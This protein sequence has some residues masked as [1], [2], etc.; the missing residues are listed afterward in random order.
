M[1]KIH[2]PYIYF[3]L[4]AA[5]ILFSRK[6]NAQSFEELAAK[7]P[8]DYAVIQN[9]SKSLTI[10]MKDGQPYAESKNEQDILVLDDKANGA[11]N[12]QYIYNN[13]YN[14][15]LDFEAYTKVPDGKKYNKIKVTDVKTESARSRS[16]FYDDTK[17]TGF[18]FPSLVKGAIAHMEYSEA[19][20]DVHMLIPFYCES[21]I[22]VV[23]AVYTVTLPTDM[24]L[25]YTV[26]NDAAKK[27][28][29]TES[30][31]GR[32]HT[33]TFT[34]SDIK[35]TDRFSN[36]PAAS[37]YEPH[38][39]IQ[40]VSYKN[41][42]GETV[43]FLGNV[44]DLYKWDYGFISR[45]NN[46]SKELKLLADSLTAGVTND[47]VKARKIYEW[48]QSNI[49]YVAFEDGLEG[50][51]PRPA[52]AICTRRYGD[53]KDMASILTALLQAAGLKAYFTWIGTRDIPYDYNDVPLPITD[54]HMIAALNTGNDW[55]FLDGTDPNCI[56][57][58]PSAFI[59]GKQAMIAISADEYKIIRVPEVDVNKSTLVDSTYITLSDNGIKGF[60]SVY[61]DG[62]FGSDIYTKLMYSDPKETKDYVKYRMGKASNKFILGNFNISKLDNIAKSVN[63]QADFE[64]P[65]YS[66]KISD[67]LYINL[68]LEK[69]FTDYS[70]IDTARRK[71]PMEN[72]YKYSIKQY[73][74]LEIP[75][76][77]NVTYIPKDFTVDNPS[78]SFAIKYTKQGNKIIA[79]QEF[80]NNYLLMQ[81]KDFPDWNNA[82]KKINN[83][84]KEQVVLEARK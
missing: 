84:Y 77:Y 23:N 33:Y 46:E 68:N 35:P 26:L 62:Y 49:K 42:K 67:E 19:Y 70:I 56:F 55:I 21:Y 51:V 81:P 58:L 8:N 69:L 7:Y 24:Q 3:F 39:I 27:I 72:D 28:N 73:T 25:K 22:P 38:I 63:I 34:A 29:V 10:F 36:A 61:Y 43:N 82:I 12:R 2:R 71:I 59:Q 57:G 66:K 76:K 41:D 1:K 79:M 4:S 54:N 30:N 32:Q 9:I 83:Q 44:N 18:D 6:A 48:V 53:C 64:V 74:V 75:E 16:I 50:F 14:S 65:D 5:V 20:K 17:Q 45:V 40:L 47:L 11:Y 60:S 52:A 80:R 15:L 37:Y 78:F 31:R 13:S